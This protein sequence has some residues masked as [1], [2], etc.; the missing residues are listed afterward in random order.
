MILPPK[1]R[2]LSASRDALRALRRAATSALGN[3]RYQGKAFL[4]DE[5]GMWG[6]P[7]MLGIDPISGYIKSVQQVSITLAS[8]AESNTATINAV[9]TATTFIVF[10]GL[11]T[12]LQ[13]PSNTGNASAWLTLTNSTTVTATRSNGYTSGEVT[14][15]CTVIEATPSLVQNV[16]YG[17]VAAT[18][19]LF[20]NSATI[21]AV[22][23]SRSAVFYLG[24]SQGGGNGMSNNI[25]VTLT[26]ST[27]VTAD[28]DHQDQW[29][30]GFVVVQFQSAVI[31]S[32]QQFTCTFTTGNTTDTQ[33][34]SSVNT[35]YTMI[36]YGGQK[37]GL[38]TST[39]QYYIQLSS[40]T[41]V[42]LVRTATTGTARSAYFTVLE[43]KPHVIKQAVQRGTITLNNVTSNTAT[44]SS[45]N[46]ART[47]CN[48]VGFNC[49]ATVTVDR[50]RLA[51][52]LTNATTI[53]GYVNTASTYDHIISYEAIEF[54][55]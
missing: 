23:T 43:F 12:P 22:D 4:S 51:L 29:V 5:R 18:S 10:Q 31:Q 17:T 49:A 36:A 47:I 25:A 32:R 55:T 13:G 40:S 41:N 48:Y 26:N 46:V 52:T 27:T 20:T 1:P 35:S 3:L 8:S 28:I 34:I 11:T 54:L 19:P 44:I 50:E 45:T 16:Q 9:N 30:V 33:T 7:A 21:A 53:T 6:L 37:Q 14:V 42:N 38:A 39:D 24:Q 2:C 15:R